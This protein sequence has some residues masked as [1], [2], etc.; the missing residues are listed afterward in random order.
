MATPLGIQAVR[1]MSR[2]TKGV[3]SDEMCLFIVCNTASIQ[4][5]PTTVAAVRSAA[6]CASPLIFCQRCG[7]PPHFGDGGDLCG[8]NS[9]ESVGVAMELFFVLLIPLILAAVAVTRDGKRGGCI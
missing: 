7:C 3:A 2:A 6:G 8:Q 5:I 1:R 4:L 9:E